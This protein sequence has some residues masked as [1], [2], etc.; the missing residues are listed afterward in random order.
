[1]CSRVF[2]SEM[3]VASRK[4]REKGKLTLSLKLELEWLGKELE[5]G[6]VTHSVIDGNFEGLLLGQ[7]IMQLSHQCC[8]WGQRSF[9]GG[10]LLEVQEDVGKGSHTIQSVVVTGGGAIKPS[11]VLQ[12]LLDEATP[13]EFI[14]G[15]FICAG[16][17][18]KKLV[19]NSFQKA[20]SSLT[21]ELYSKG[22]RSLSA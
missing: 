16:M 3:R 2:K 9:G 18:E 15:E 13:Q 11:Q 10:W 5:R 12:Q 21:G 8:D 14:R 20:R 7:S 22:K 1:M 19:R 6:C 17:D 4:M